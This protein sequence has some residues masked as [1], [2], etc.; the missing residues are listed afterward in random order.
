M[1]TAID[2]VV[3][4]SVASVLLTLAF[5]TVPVEQSDRPPSRPRLGRA[6]PGD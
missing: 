4:V 2:V 3:G 5:S 6:S 1:K